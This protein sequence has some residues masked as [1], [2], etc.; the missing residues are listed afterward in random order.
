MIFG[1]AVRLNFGLY[2]R[3]TYKT[4][5]NTFY[6]VL[7]IESRNKDHGCEFFQ[8]KKHFVR[9]KDLFSKETSSYKTQSIV[10]KLVVHSLE[11]RL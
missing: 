10:C 7:I 8:L 2:K 11:A 4:S 6:W 3:R 5:S 9:Y 1:A